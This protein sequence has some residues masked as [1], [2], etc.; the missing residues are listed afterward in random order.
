MEYWDFSVRN[1]MHL[2]VTGYWNLLYSLEST[3]SHRLIAFVW[4]ISTHSKIALHMQERVWHLKCK[5]IPAI[6]NVDAIGCN[7]DVAHTVVHMEIQN[8]ILW[9]KM[10]YTPFSAWKLSS[11]D[12]PKCF[13]FW[14]PHCVMTYVPTFIKNS[15]GQFKTNL[16]SDLFAMFYWLPIV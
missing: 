12:R 4:H 6:L 5:Y 9:W 15:I 3:D 13:H 8:Q 1:R 11:I 10:S 14:R 16:K 7:C 2:C